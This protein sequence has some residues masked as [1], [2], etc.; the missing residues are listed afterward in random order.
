[1]NQQPNPTE[2]DRVNQALF[3]GRFI[4][5][6]KIYRSATGCDLK[7]SKDFIEALEDR[8]RAEMPERFSGPP[9]KK[10]EVSTAG[11]AMVLVGIVAAIV[12]AVWLLN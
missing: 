10:L 7:E 8:L 6:I 2:M 5:A 12:G 11:C 4:E 3:A 1:M 9:R